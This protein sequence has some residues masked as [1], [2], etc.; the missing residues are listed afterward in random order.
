[1]ITKAVIEAS[2]YGGGITFAPDRPQYVQPVAPREHQVE[3]DTVIF[4][5]IQHRHRVVEGERP[6]ADV[7][8]RAEVGDDAVGELALVLYDQKFH[9]R[10]ATIFKKGCCKNSNN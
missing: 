6:L 7:P 8:L 5:T 4:I 1:M 10:F 9:C 3:E 2:E